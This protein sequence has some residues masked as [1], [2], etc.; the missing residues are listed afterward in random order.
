MHKGHNK[1][2]NNDK[3]SFEAKVF[4]FLKGQACSKSEATSTLPSQK[5]LRKY[6]YSN[7][8]ISSRFADMFAIQKIFSE[9]AT[10]SS[11]KLIQYSSIPSF[12][13]EL[14]FIQFYENPEKIAF[15]IVQASPANALN[16]IINFVNRLNLL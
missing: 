16:K 11:L 3:F 8:N 12:L 15:I 13:T 7:E 2:N 1:N 9:R 10:I 4:L 14:N 6:A 5:S